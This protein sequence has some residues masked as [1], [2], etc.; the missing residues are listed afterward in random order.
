M[1]KNKT[2]ETDLSVT[3]FV[4]AQKGEAKRKDSFALIELMAADTARIR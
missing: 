2:T 3:D 4:N 1:A